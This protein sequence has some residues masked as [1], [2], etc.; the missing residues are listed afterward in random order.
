MMGAG[1]YSKRAMAQGR[2]DWFYRKCIG[3]QLRFALFPKRCDI[4]NRL[5]WLEYAYR[6][7]AVLTGPGDS[8]VE[9]RWHDRHE[10]II[11]KIKGY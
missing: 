3:W 6:G 1:Y 10:H 5:I 2:D 9:H 7:T 11:F 4:T 8:I